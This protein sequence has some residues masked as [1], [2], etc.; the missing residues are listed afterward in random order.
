MAKPL[1]DDG[2]WALFQSL[3]PPP[4]ARRWRYPGRKPVDDRKA[5]TG[6]VF[7]LKTGIPW[8]YLPKEMGCGSG[9]TCWRRLRQ[10][11]KLGIWQRS[12]ELL[13]AKLQRAGRIDW[14][15]GIVGSSSIRAFFGG[16][17]RAGIPRI[18]AKWAAS[19]I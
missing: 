11:Q 1:V 8:S 12:H 2:L 5:F 13:L 9:V 16:R 6:I 15:R 19:T 14:S 10:W 4:K 7:V 17:R 3:L 18:A